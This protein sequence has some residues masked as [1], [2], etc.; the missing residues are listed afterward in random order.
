MAPSQHVISPAIEQ[1]ESVLNSEGGRGNLP[2]GQPLVQI[3]VIAKDPAKMKSSE[4]ANPP[5][6]LILWGG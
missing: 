6:G 5:R 3:L 1:E 2:I 4:G